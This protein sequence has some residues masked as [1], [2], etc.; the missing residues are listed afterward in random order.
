MV[1]RR[2]FTRR[3]ID[4][5]RNLVDA[6]LSAH[7]ALVDAVEDEAP[8]GTIETTLADFDTLYF[9]GLALALDRLYV[10]RPR[11]GSGSGSGSLGEL[12]RIVKSITDNED[13]HVRLTA[14][15]FERLADGVFAELEKKYPA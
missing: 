1:E 7:M 13:D 5:G 15:Q 14:E 4:N 9:D 8:D 11:D 12:A 3:E 2:G 10:E 6:A